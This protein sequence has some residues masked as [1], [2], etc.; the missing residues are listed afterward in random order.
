MR[1]A[2]A[3]VVLGLALAVGTVLAGLT[4]LDVLSQDTSSVS[5]ADFAVVVTTGAIDG[6]DAEALHHRADEQLY[7]AK[8]A[9]RNVTI[10]AD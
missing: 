8:S 5:P 9:G 7:A 3:G 1:P 2:A 10:A 6:E 4:E